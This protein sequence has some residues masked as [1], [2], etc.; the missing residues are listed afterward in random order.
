MFKIAITK[1]AIGIYNFE[2]NVSRN[3]NIWENF[4][5]HNP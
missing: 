2:Q 5:Y 1:S 3:F 4:A